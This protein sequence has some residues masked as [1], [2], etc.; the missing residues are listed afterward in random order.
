MAKAYS[1]KTRESI[2]LKFA[3][4]HKG[5]HSIAE[6]ASFAG[7]SPST[8]YVWN[9]GEAWAKRGGWNRNHW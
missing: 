7:I 6:S 5:G 1:D 9:R 2:R 4:H 3:K 8:F